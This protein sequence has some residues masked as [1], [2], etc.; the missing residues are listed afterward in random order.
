MNG[1]TRTA[2]VVTREALAESAEAMELI[3]K[4]MIP[5]LDEVER[6]LASRAIR[7]SLELIRLLLTARGQQPSGRVVIG[8]FK[9]DLHDIGKNLV[10][11][12]LEGGGF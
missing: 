7:G 1:D 8:T 3:S 4:H 11:S 2:V 10:A 9:G 12:V 5:L 6:L